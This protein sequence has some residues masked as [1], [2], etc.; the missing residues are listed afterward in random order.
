MKKHFCTLLCVIFLAVT[1]IFG[2]GN[3]IARAENTVEETSEIDWESLYYDLLEEY[4]ELLEKY[5]AVINA[6]DNTVA[7]NIENPFSEAEKGD[8]IEFGYYEQDG[9]VSNGAEVIEWRVLAI[10]D[11]KALIISEYGLD[12]MR[13]N[14]DVVDITWEECTLRGWLNDDFYNTAFTEEEQARIALT[15]L[16]NDDNLAYSTEGGND[17]D[18]KVFLMS[19][20]EAKE[21]FA[22]DEDRKAFATRYAQN[23][24]AFV[25]DTGEIRWWL[26]SPGTVEIMA[27]YIYQDGGIISNGMSIT[28]RNVVVRPALWI[29]LE[30]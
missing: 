19:V 11:G 15:Q 5:E 18:D 16:I 28:Q 7:E 24:G 3:Y 22:D 17:T 20:E 1:N 29:N 4:N 2:L 26:R 14:T 12:A 6:S 10:E 21:Y 27:A 23:H 13:Y 25:S 8:L 9:D 30:Q